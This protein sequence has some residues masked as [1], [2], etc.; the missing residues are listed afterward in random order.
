MQ[1]AVDIVQ[2]AWYCQ[3]DGAACRG[4]LLL[5]RAKHQTRTCCAAQLVTQ[6]AYE[7][8]EPKNTAFTMLQVPHLNEPP[9]YPLLPAEV[10]TQ[11]LLLL[12]PRTILCARNASILLHDPATAA[13]A[14]LFA[15]DGHL[16]R[17]AWQIC[18]FYLSR[19]SLP[20]SAYASFLASLELEAGTVR[21]KTPSI[22]SPR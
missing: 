11:V 3:Q 15:R 21:Y 17:R 19:S 18:I 6:A 20:R 7:Y 1:E 14:A 22:T 9:F 2:G 8:I 16:S 10:I 5:A 13:I 4:S 12:P